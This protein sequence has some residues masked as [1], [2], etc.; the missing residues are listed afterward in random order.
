MKNKWIPLKN[1]ITGDG[2]ELV[3]TA[4]DLESALIGLFDELQHDDDFS[5][6]AMTILCDKWEK[7]MFDFYHVT[8]WNNVKGEHQ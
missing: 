5:C 2:E 6:L 4:I 1:K 7:W 8:D 3:I